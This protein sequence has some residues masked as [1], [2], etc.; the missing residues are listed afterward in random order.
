LLLPVGV[1]FA[2]DVA[3]AVAMAHCV[4]ALGSKTLSHYKCLS[5]NGVAAASATATAIATA[6]A[7]AT[8]TAAVG[9]VQFN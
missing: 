7:I 2:A 8:A 5:F 1:A 3:A 4:S 9:I 6:I